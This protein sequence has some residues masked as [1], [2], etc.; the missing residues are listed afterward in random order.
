MSI[1]NESSV[2]QRGLIFGVC[3]LLLLLNW[4]R[5]I[6]DD[7]GGATTVYLSI[8]FTVTQYVLNGYIRL[9]N[10]PSSWLIKSILYVSFMFHATH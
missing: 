9:F 10:S 4:L 8:T 7:Q 2:V 1:K 6:M 3:F 5:F